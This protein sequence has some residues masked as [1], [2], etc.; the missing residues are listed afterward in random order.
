MVSAIS[1]SWGALSGNTANSRQRL[2]GQSQPTRSGPLDCTDK[3]TD[4]DPR[5][6]AR[7]SVQPLWPDILGLAPV[8]VAQ[9]MHGKS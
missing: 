9:L 4:P 5:Y 8:G 3:R 1:G 7:V 2:L 6:T